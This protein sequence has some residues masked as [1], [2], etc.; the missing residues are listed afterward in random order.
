MSHLPGARR[1]EPGPG[2]TPDLLG[3]PRDT[4]IVAYCAVGY[5]SAVLAERLR[6][7]GFTNVRNLTGSI[8][9]WA[10]E[11]GAMESDTGPVEVV[12]PYD[13]WWGLLLKGQHRARY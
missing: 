6:Q 1:I 11:G 5:R 2:L 4:P 8:F 9:R 10:N 13:R 3:F 7:E 12:E